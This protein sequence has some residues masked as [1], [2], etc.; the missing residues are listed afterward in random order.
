MAREAPEVGYLRTFGCVAFTK[1]LSQFK[2]LDDRSIPGILIGYADGAKAYR[3]FDPAA[4]RVRVSRDVVFNES[5]GWDWIKAGGGQA[6]ADEEFVVERVE[7]FGSGERARLH[8]AWPRLRLRRA[9]RPLFCLLGRK[10]CRSRGGGGYTAPGVP[11]HASGG[12]L[13]F[14]PSNRAG[15][16]RLKGPYLALVIE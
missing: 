12:F 13:C 1:D 10:Q 5:R 7:E 3:I 15:Y 14:N 8:R 16:A 2:K 6:P 11:D 9:R 4:Q